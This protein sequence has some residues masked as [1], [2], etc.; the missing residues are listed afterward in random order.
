VLRSVSPAPVAPHRSP[1]LAHQVAAL[2]ATLDAHM[3]RFSVAG[4]SSAASSSPAAIAAHHRSVQGALDCLVGLGGLLGSDGRNLAQR[5]ACTLSA[6]VF[7]APGDA[8]SFAGSGASNRTYRQEL[9]AMTQRATA[10]EGMVQALLQDSERLQLQAQQHVGRLPP[11]ESKV[12]EPSV[13]KPTITLE[14]FYKQLDLLAKNMMGTDVLEQT[15]NDLKQDLYRAD[16]QAVRSKRDERDVDRIRGFGRSQSS[17]PL[18]V[19]A[20]CPFSI[21]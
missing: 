14:R 4:A 16:V 21:I 13:G 12:V 19:L 17:H 20:Q 10:A 15:I 7:S 2:S 5:V 3:A 18:R 1:A 9:A 8:T 6:A 11:A